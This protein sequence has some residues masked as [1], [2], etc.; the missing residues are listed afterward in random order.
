MID[1]SVENSR[2]NRQSNMNP[3]NSRMPEFITH[4]MLNNQP[5]TIIN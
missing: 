1:V 4:H 5:I 3:A 2:F